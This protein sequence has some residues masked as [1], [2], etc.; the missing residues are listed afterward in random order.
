LSAFS[1]CNLRLIAD[2]NFNCGEAR[3]QIRG[4]SGD[5][6]ARKCPLSPQILNDFPH[7]DQH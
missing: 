6:A 3:L 4:K 2:F 1:H 7:A 5:Q